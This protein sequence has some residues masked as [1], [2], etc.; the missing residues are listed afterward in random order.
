MK[1][2]PTAVQAGL[3]RGATLI[4]AT[5]QRQAAIRAAWADAQRTSGATLWQTPRVLTFTQF[6]ERALQ[7]AWAHSREPDRLLPPAAEWAALREWRREEGGTAEARAL[8]SAVRALGDWRIP[9]TPQ[10]LGGFPE[11]ELLLGAVSRLAD[12]SQQRQRKSLREW[13]P[14]INASG[15]PLFAAGLSSLAAGPRAA[16]KRW[17]A[18]DTEPVVP[19]SPVKVVAAEDDDHELELIA[20]WCREQLER[21]PQRRLLVVDA[22]L[23]QRRGLY[24]RVLSQTL[25]PSQW[26]RREARPQSTIY[27]VE[28]G[29]PFAEF[30]AVAHAMLS[31]RL[32]TGRLRFDEL[33]QWLRMPFLDLADHLAGAAVEGLL[34]QSRKLES[35]A[36]E[37]ANTLVRDDAPAA[38]AQMAARMRQAI[39]VLGDERRSAAE[40]SP[41]LL[42]ALRLL[43]WPGSRP[44]NSDEQQTVARLHAL[45]DEYAALGAWLPRSSAADAV[46]TLSDLAA[47]RQFDPATVDAPI[48]LSDS[49]EDPVV[50]YDAIWVSGL[51][52]AQWPPPPRPD[53]FIPLR[54]QVDAGLPAAS[55][56]GQTQAARRSLAAW[57]AAADQLTCSWARLEGDAHRSISPLL[58]RLDARADAPA[59]T[60]V[61]P[62]AAQVR[63]PPLESFED[64]QG[65]EVDTRLPVPG[66]THPLQLQAECGFHAYA[67]VR[68]HGSDLEEPT[69]GIDPR[70]RG[71]LLHKALELVWIKLKDHLHLKESE[72]LRA[73]LI[74]D[75]VEAA[76]AS[77]FRGYVPTEMRNAVEREKH[78][79][80]KLIES[81]LLLEQRRPT[82]EVVALETRREVSIAGGRF[83]V[84]IDRIDS[85]EG[86]GQAI[87]D[88]KSGEA[89]APRWQGEKIRDPQLLAYLWAENGRNVQALAYVSLVNGQAKFIGK[90]S[91]KNLLPGV[92]GLPGPVADASD[93][94]LD[95]AWREELQSWLQGLMHIASDYIAGHAPV[96]PASDVCRNCHL[97]VLCRRVELNA[98]ALE[99]DEHGGD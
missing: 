86:G 66:G 2:L 41:R 14:S 59:E 58:Q 22:K 56:S 6:A 46:A 76:V 69:P 96:E 90:S 3:A 32:L 85:M 13:L 18:I 30:P 48:T 50:R 64:I 39:A 95:A 84:R 94:S 53:P 71:K 99:G 60:V 80:E 78:R 44:L 33:V 89:R 37:F 7:D 12:L 79:L 62:L 63:K 74:A 10:T 49:H 92:G 70:D 34:R 91:R 35:T 25:S 77:V 15:E 31:L 43:G 51:D 61:A 83:V 23:R 40:W 88:Y 28:G 45:L 29:R 20:T 47:E 21:D 54:L 8:L 36:A 87:L 5:A 97:T 75:S 73:T 11:G 65:S 9:A 16:L 24:D 38:A 57:R 55:A 42:Q 26:L 17:G 1:R 81:L 19:A 68:L 98:A 82:F 67:E 4:C 93:E 27:T 72:G 52:A